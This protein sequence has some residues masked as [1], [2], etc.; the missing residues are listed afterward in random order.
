[1]EQ[2]YVLIIVLYKILNTEDSERPFKLCKWYIPYNPEINDMEPKAILVVFAV[3]AVTTMLLV[4]AVS[5]VASA[6]SVLAVKG[7]GGRGQ[8][9]DHGNDRDHFG[10]EKDHGSDRG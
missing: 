9:R 4:S 10:Q 6:P 7:E 1:M 5:V 8:E 3:V 2:K